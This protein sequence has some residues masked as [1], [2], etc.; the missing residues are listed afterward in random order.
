[1]GSFYWLFLVPGAAMS[2]LTPTPITIDLAQQMQIAANREDWDALLK[3]CL[4]SLATG[5]M[6]DIGIRMLG[7]AL[8][9]L[10]RE[11]EAKQAYETALAIFPEMANLNSNY[12]VTLG[13][14]GDLAGAH[15]FAKKAGQ[16]APESS[17]LQLNWLAACANIKAH[18][19]AIVVAKNALTLPLEPAMRAMILTNLANVYRMQGQISDAVSAFEKAIDLEPDTLYSFTNLILTLQSDPS[20]DDLHIFNTTQR[21]AKIIEAPFE[22]DWP[23]FTT[24][25]QGPNRQLRIGFLSPDFCNHPVTYF[26]EGLVAQL[27]RQ[28]FIVE[29]FYLSHKQDDTTQRIR[30]YADHF[31]EIAGLPIETQLAIIRERQIDILIDLAGHTAD[32]G[33]TI[34]ARKAAPVQASWLGFPGSTGL[35]SIDWR[36]TDRIASPVGE[37]NYYSERLARMPRISL[38]YRPLARALPLRYLRKYTVQPTPALKNGYITFGTCNHLAKI[39]EEVLQLWSEILNCV[40]KSRLLVEGHKLEESSA[41]EAF[42]NKCRLAG[43]DESRLLL[44]Q[45][46]AAN[47]YLTYNHIDVALDPFP[48]T[49]GTTTFDTLWMGVPL[50]TLEGKTFR[51]RMGVSILHALGHPEWIGRDKADYVAKACRLAENI[52]QLNALRL[53]LRRQVDGSPLTD[54]T[55]FTRIYEKMLRDFWWQW[56][57]SKQLPGDLPVEQRLQKMTATFTEWGNA[58]KAPPPQQRV[59]TEPGQA[60]T[61]A[62][63]EEVLADK[64]NAAKKYLASEPYY[65]VAWQ[66]V[67]NW[68]QLLLASIP[69]HPGALLSL[70]EVAA[71]R[72]E[73]EN[74]IDYAYAANQ[75]SATT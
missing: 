67:E 38:A 31:H 32:N 23:D 6:S 50:I 47:Q 52:E 46:D 35:K 22:A 30:R 65:V 69:G 34:M 42:I 66:S 18:D 9:R 63:A 25:A 51:S 17:R 28:Q 4:Q 61:L 10:G 56:L 44:V 57:A 19:E 16:L 54:E 72:G 21:Y 8:S 36:I 7:L 49:G 13:H 2:D 33:L 41:R 43:I 64:L 37:G 5:E 24:L 55:G 48:L 14:L 39:S 12:S 11:R 29:C 74:A 20:A 3:L 68:A 27:D 26:I 60:M 62:A 58:Q 53:D 40:P 45:R 75:A 59:C 71:S 73:Q 1:M 70:A 15:Q